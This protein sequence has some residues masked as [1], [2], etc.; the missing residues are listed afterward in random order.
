MRV[1]LVMKSG[2][3]SRIPNAE[4]CGLYLMKVASISTPRRTRF[5]KETILC[6]LWDQKEIVYYELLNPKEIVN[7]DRYQQLIG[8]NY[9]YV[10][11]SEWYCTTTM[12]FCIHHPGYK[13]S[14]TAS[15]LFTRPSSFEESQNWLEEWFLSKD[16]LE[17]HKIFNFLLIKKSRNELSH[18]C[19]ILTTFN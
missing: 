9:A 16:T 12:L 14:T 15:T 17:Q 8:L 3:T 13:Q 5:E 4:N 11:M 19:I 6:I 2:S 10:E 1:L 18:F 7:A